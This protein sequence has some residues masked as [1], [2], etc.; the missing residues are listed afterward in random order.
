MTDNDTQPLDV[1][2]IGGGPAGLTA[3]IYASRAGLKTLII[4]G[5]T[6]TSQITMTDLIENFP[7]VPEGTS[8]FDLVESFRKQALSFGAR[9]ATADVSAVRK[10]SLGGF[11]GWELVCGGK[12][13]DALAVVVATGS[14]WRRLGAEGEERFIGRGVSFCATCDGPLYR[15]RE[16][17]VV[18]GGNSAIQ[19]ALFLTHFASK[20]TVIH[21]RDRL[22][23]DDVLQKRAF[24]NP[25]IEFA[26]SSVVKEIRGGD[27]VE[28]VTI[29]PAGG[30]GKERVLPAEGVFIFVGLTPNTAMVTDVVA[31]D[32]QGYITADAD[33]KT[34]AAGIFAAGDCI[35]KTLHQVVTACGDGATAAYSAQLYVEALKGE[36]Y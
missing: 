19:E 21:R 8:G 4:E 14:A 15:N 12:T 34:S 30:E 25:K 35:H 23:A 29:A 13:F 11:E 5:S 27:L 36:S 31:R 26:W 6:V 1:A 16:V 22:R 17:V 9:T 10:K 18:G 33:M 3:G 24:A 7:G 28:G 32:A 2:I 20:V